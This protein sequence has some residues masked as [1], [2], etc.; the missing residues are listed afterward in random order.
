MNLTDKKITFLCFTV[1]IIG[2]VSLHFYNQSPQPKKIADINEGD[3]VKITGTIQ[4]MN[5]VKDKYGHIKKIKCI[6]LSDESGGDLR[7][8]AFKDVNRKL[9]EYI[10]STNPTIKEGDVVEVIG[11]VR[12]YKGLYEIVLNNAD[13]FKLIK[14]KNFKRDIYLSPTPTGI[15]ASKYGKT[16]HTC[17]NCPYGKKIKK[18]NRI[19]FY[20]EEDA[21]ELGYTK[22]K[23]CSKNE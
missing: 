9:T 14:K 12:V 16:Y 4:S 7:I 22:C 1:V 5:A 3:Y 21:K 23:W 2:V 10:K 15:Y 19:Y 11:T 8:Y 17:N 20:S 6:I 18:D 13:D